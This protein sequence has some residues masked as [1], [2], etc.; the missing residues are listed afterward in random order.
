MYASTVEEFTTIPHLAI[1]DDSSKV[2][3][4]ENGMDAID[5]QDKYEAKK[6]SITE[7]F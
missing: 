7:F 5:E 4:K 1:A 6:V 2:L 3:T